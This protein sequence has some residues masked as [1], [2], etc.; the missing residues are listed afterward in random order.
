VRRLAT[1]SFETLMGCGAAAAAHRGEQLPPIRSLFVF[2]RLL[3][4]AAV[5]AVALSGCSTATV[6]RGLRLT[7]APSNLAGTQGQ[8]LQ[9][10]TVIHRSPTAGG[11]LFL[12]LQN[13]PAGIHGVF[14]PNPARGDSSILT[15]IVDES[16]VPGDY[17]IHVAGRGAFAATASFRVAVAGR[18]LSTAVLDGS[19]R[20]SRPE[21]SPFG[22]GLPRPLARV[23]DAKGYK[24]DFVQDELIVVTDD[25]AALASIVSRWRGSVL[26]TIRP[27]DYG[28]NRTKTIHLLR[29][30]ASAADTSAL[31]R[32]LTAINPN[33]RGDFRVSSPEGLS[34]IAAAAHEAAR[35]AR[36]EVNWVAQP[37]LFENKVSSEA[38]VGAQTSGPPDYDPNAFSWGYMRTKSGN[39]IGVADAWRVLELEGKLTNKI[40]IAILDSGFSANADYPAG[41]Q[42]FA[43]N[44]GKQMGDMGTGSPWHGSRVLQTV[45]ALPGNGFGT[46]GVAGPVASVIMVYVEGD[47]FNAMAALW[48]AEGAGAR[49]INMSFGAA[50]PAFLTLWQSNGQGIFNDETAETRAAGI[51]IFAGAG[52]DGINVDAYDGPWEEAWHAPCENDGVI[53]VGGQTS[54]LATAAPEIQ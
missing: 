15:L 26:K 17:E 19:V 36:V 7:M 50:V 53:C 18:R 3:G 11:D 42:F 39:R 20:P 47:L 46:A 12:T 10:T 23:V 14:N 5:T 49:I 16:A 45:A 54:A 21:L 51:L 1:C 44:S 4:I 40:K 33:V 13:P 37:S 9:V 34:L 6:G 25:A 41:W 35:G 43:V 30:D 48:N 8:S 29:I 32:N 31:A 52:N 28:V 24:V 27:T 2:A 38:P 22:D